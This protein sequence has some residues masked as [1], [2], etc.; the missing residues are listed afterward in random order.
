MRFSSPWKDCFFQ[1][2]SVAN[3]CKSQVERMIIW[4]ERE[5]K[6]AEFFLQFQL[7]RAT[8]IWN[9]QGLQKPIGWKSLNLQFLYKTLSQCMGYHLPVRAAPVSYSS[10]V[11]TWLKFLTCHLI[12]G[13]LPD[14]AA[15]PKFITVCHKYQ[16]ICKSMTA[17][18]P[19]VCWV[20]K[21]YHRKQVAIS[22]GNVTWTPLKSRISHICMT[23]VRWNQITETCV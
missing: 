8:F 21:L 22:C 7:N 11:S 9:K 13:K 3:H 18:K 5:R 20:C 6:E 23:A 1:E 14:T 2:E 4:G 15:D 16:I 12:P 10:W 17:H 19:R